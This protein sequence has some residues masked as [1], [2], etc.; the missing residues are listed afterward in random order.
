[1]T[2]VAFANR[3]LH[4]NPSHA[5]AIVYDFD[6]LGLVDTLIKTGPSATCI[7]LGG[8]RKK[9]SPAPF[10]DINARLPKMVIFT[11]VRAFRSFFAEHTVF[12]GCQLLLPFI[13]GFG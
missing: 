11:H 12:F 2:Q 6:D 13:F 10:A 5:K 9:F 8:G 4:F 7:K 1:M 3:T